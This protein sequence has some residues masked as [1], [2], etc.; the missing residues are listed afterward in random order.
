MIEGKVDPEAAPVS[1]QRLSIGGLGFCWSRNHVRLGDE[2]PVAHP[3]PHGRGLPYLLAHANCQ[4]PF[5]VLGIDHVRVGIG[6]PRIDHL[7]QQGRC[8]LIH[9]PTRLC[10]ARGS[11]GRWHPMR[12]VSPMSPTLR[13]SFLA[14]PRR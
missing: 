6:D 9:Q 2:A 10:R 4:A 5:D 3:E 14:A 12:N 11:V 7:S 1:Y 13:P 8:L